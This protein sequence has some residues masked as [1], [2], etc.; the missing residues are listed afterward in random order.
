MYYPYFR[1]K[2][3][4]LYALTQL[5]EKGL[6]SSKV[7]PIIEP[8]KKSKAL[9][10]LL[11][12]FQ[13]AEQPFYLIENPQAG[14][15]L[16]LDGYEYLKELALP[17]AHIIDQ[18][19]NTEEFSKKLLIVRDALPTLE[20]DWAST[21]TI[22]VV[23]EEFRLLQKVQGAKILSQD[24]FTRLPKTRFYQELRD[25]SFSNAHLT[26][27]KRGFAGFCD[28]SIDS[29][30]YYEH[31]YPSPIL[32]L[33]LVYFE[34]EKLRVHHFL[35]S[36]EAPTQKDKFCELIE[37]VNTWNLRLWGKAPTLGIQLLQ[38]AYEKDKFPGMGVMRKAA[39]MHHLELMS[40]YL[41][42]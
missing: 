11:T 34:G 37:A 26:F 1:G 15:L 28:Y 31:G 18:P 33:H 8:V 27:K 32:S 6:L 12:V 29:R 30:I 10:K 24:P 22:T 20:N 4:D 19:L 39:V 40:R 13:K 35:S 5:V 25:E 36:E 38:E 3:F 16:T 14:D 41:E 9:E 17:K 23:P 2:Q 7:I 21:Q 42:K